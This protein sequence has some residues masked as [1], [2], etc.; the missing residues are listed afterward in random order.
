MISFTKIIYILLGIIILTMLIS[1]VFNF[2][3]IEFA[4]YGN[5]LLWLIALVIFYIVLPSND[6]SIF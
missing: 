4:T 2:L 3:G 6:N 1:L 5:Y